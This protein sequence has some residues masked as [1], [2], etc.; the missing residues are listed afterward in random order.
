MTDRI[1]LALILLAGCPAPDRDRS[2][3]AADAD[4]SGGICDRTGFCT[5]RCGPSYGACLPG[6]ECRQGLCRLPCDVE[7]ELCE[8]SLEVYAEPSTCQLHCDRYNVIGSCAHGVNLCSAAGDS[9]GGADES[10]GE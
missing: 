5:E 10:E 3:C 8:V 7:P 2:R 9:S 1:L 6:E 4:C